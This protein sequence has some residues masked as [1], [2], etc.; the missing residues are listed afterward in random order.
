[1][2]IK[3]LVVKNI[4]I[5]ATLNGVHLGLQPYGLKKIPE[6]LFIT[7]SEEKKLLLQPEVELK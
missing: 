3:K 2:A 1:M 6:N 7:H 5:R 4:L